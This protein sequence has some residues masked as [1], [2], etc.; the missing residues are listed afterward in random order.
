MPPS[1]TLSAATP[2]ASPA[3]RNS[4]L[5][6]AIEGLFKA[7]D[8]GM[9]AATFNSYIACLAP[10]GAVRWH[11]TGTTPETTDDP[12]LI[13]LARDPQRA[14]W[15]RAHLPSDADTPDLRED[16]EWLGRQAGVRLRQLDETV[17]LYDA[18]SRLAQAERLQRALYDIADQAMTDRDMDDVMRSLHGIVGSL[19]YAENFYIVLYDAREDAIRFTYAA[20]SSDMDMPHKAQMIPMAELRHSLTW[21]LIRGGRSLMGA[22]EELTAQID[23]PVAPHGP[24]CVDWLGVP[25]LRG[26]DVTGALVVQS[27]REDSHY[28]EQDRELLTYVAQ[29]VQTALERRHAHAEL[30]RRVAERTEELREANRVLQQQVLER[31]RGEKLQAA[32]FRIAE[33]ANTA[34]SIDDFYAALHGV[35]GG[36]LYARNFYIALLHEDQTRLTFPYSVDERDVRREARD[37]G[38]GLTEYVLRNGRPLLANFEDL[39]TMRGQGE[40]VQSGSESDCW[41]GVPLICDERVEGVLAVQSYTREQ[42]YTQRDQELLTFVSYHVAN[43]LQRKRGADA[44]KQGNVN[45][46]RRVTERT[47]ALALANR[48]LREQIAERER[49][50]RRLKYETLHD[51]LTGLPN[52]ALLLQRLDQALQ[53]YHSDPDQLFAVL[54]IDLDRFKVINDSVGHL[55]GDDLLFQVGGRIRACL[56]TRDLV[57]RLGGDEFAVLVEGIEDLDFVKAIADRIIEELHAPFRIGA[58]ELFTSASIGIT[59]ASNHYHRAEELLRDADSAMYSAKAGGR[60]R[61]ELFDDR[62]RRSAVSQLEMEGDLRRALTRD[63]FEPYYQPIVRLSDGRICGYEALMRWQHPERGLLLPGDFLTI[64]EDSGCDE[65]IDWKIFDKVFA[66][67]PALTGTDGFIS[68]NLSGQ[69]FRSPDIGDRL[70]ELLGRHRGSP[71]N[72]RVE[73]TERTLLENPEQ[74][75]C[76]LNGLRHRGITIA[77]DDFGTGYSSLSYMHQ[78]PIEVLKIDRSFVIRLDG[79]GADQDQGNTEAD[80][81]GEAIVRAIQALADSLNMQVIAEGIETEEQRHA[82]RRIGCRFGQGFLFHH[83]QPASHWLKD[84]TAQG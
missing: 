32:L 27:Y 58:K 57:S 42:R 77:L 33:M 64:A 37:L 68:I 17:H 11:A 65:S 6:D 12:H 23:G 22:I 71:H 34:D 84:S 51:T 21:H 73:V 36:L 50:E 39:E 75:K 61:A 35:I 76:S 40:L 3:T 18:V 25:L 14:Q 19:M 59:L 47:R 62:L 16:L 13:D 72:L 79:H 24:A 5:S 41:L 52:R 20:D 69:H 70:L 60:H 31:Q 67:M 66:D 80:D 4:A 83:A 82:L 46:E 81:Q 56:K 74:V 30:E 9:I 43:A 38:H 28:T 63:E 44:L 53:R 7:S 45:L 78:Y 26:G 54:F 49:V 2:S 1:S 55:I 15:L 48:D 29:H 8:I 10:G